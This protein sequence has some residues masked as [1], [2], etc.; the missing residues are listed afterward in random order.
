MSVSSLSILPAHRV[1]YQR[2][3]SQWTLDEARCSYTTGSSSK[4]RPIWARRSFPVNHNWVEESVLKAA[5][6][7]RLFMRPQTTQ[8]EGMV[9]LSPFYADLKHVF[10]VL[11]LKPYLIWYP[12]TLF[13]FAKPFIYIEP[14]QTSEMHQF[15]KLSSHYQLYK[16]PA[17][18]SCNIYHN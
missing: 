16:N 14:S 10:L 13:S 7:K 15:K 18:N 8:S 2:N 4:I 3:S 11:T 1:I 5:R 12:N 9:S 6:G 17:I